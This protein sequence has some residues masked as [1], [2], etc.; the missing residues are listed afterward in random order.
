MKKCKGTGK[1]KGFGCGIELPYTERNGIK[2]YKATYGLGHDCKCYY[3]WLS[4]D[5]PEAKEQFNK[6]IISNKK[7]LE[8]EK[9]RVNREL[10]R[11]T[12]SVDE[13]R[14]K[15]VQPKI[16]QIAREIDFG[17]PCIS[18]GNYGKMNGGHF[19][20]IGSNRTTAINLHNIHIQSFHSNH[21]KSGDKSKYRLGI[22]EIYGSDYFD[23]IE[24]L[25]GC[26]V[27]KLNKIELEEIKNNAISILK[28]LK[29]NQKIRTPK[30]HIKLRNEINTKLNIYSKKFSE[31]N[32]NY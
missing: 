7:K 15:Y 32:F 17:Q 24:S 13:Y 26:P 18:S 30:E 21:W 8:D 12:I 10:K 3:K 4:G 19:I 31:F 29:Q 27:L 14:A 1:A 6:L 5:T 9:K 16:N 28:E 25:H 11:K 22:I 2:S 20:D 23:F